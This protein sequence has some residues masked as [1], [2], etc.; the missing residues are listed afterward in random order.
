MRILA[1]EQAARL[2]HAAE[3]E[4]SIFLALMVFARLHDGEAC[5]VQVG[6]IDWI[7]RK[8]NIVRQI[9]YLGAAGIEIKPPKDESARSTAAEPMAQVAGRVAA[10]QTG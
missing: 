10:Q 1:P 3:D 2:I 5:A 9:Q 7:G 8:L 4:F 6:D